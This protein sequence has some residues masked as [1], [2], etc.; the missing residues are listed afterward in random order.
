VSA[1]AVVDEKAGSPRTPQEE[2]AIAV[3]MKNNQMKRPAAVQA[4]A[5]AKKQGTSLEQIIGEKEPAE[6]TE[7][8]LASRKL[9]PER[10]L[11]SI[12]F[13][14]I[15]DWTD[16]ALASHVAEGFKKFAAYIP[17]AIE[18]RKRFTEHERDSMNRLVVPILGCSTWEEF[19]N[20]HFDRTSRAVNKAMRIA[21]KA[22]SPDVP[23]KPVAEAEIPE[24]PERTVPNPADAVQTLEIQL[25]N[26][27]TE[28]TRADAAIVCRSFIAYIQ[29]ELTEI[30]KEAA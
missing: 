30:E 1:A 16:E 20:Q 14:N 27:I 25:R 29:N 4:L 12:P 18:L 11:S 8:A 2:E 24:I 28:M 7:T 22:L 19:C 21:T 23:Q 5:L 15:T 9:V 6:S 10:S 3:L 13:V 26:L 17:H